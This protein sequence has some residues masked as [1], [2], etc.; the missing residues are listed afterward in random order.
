[1][2]GHHAGVD[3]VQ[4]G[5]AYDLAEVGGFGFGVGG[6]VVVDLLPGVVGITG[7]LG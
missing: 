4:V 1:M 6:D 5:G 2:S 7:G 3:H